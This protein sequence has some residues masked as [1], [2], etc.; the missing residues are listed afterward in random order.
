MK[1]K[2][3]HI[4]LL[5]LSLVIAA[6]ASGCAS[7]GSGPK[8]AYPT[9]RNTEVNVDWPM[10]RYNNAVTAGRV[11]L[12]M[13]QEVNQAYTA[14]KQAFDAALAAAN[15]NR[16]AHTPDNVQALANQL[17]TTLGGVPTF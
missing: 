2:T 9:L 14:Y 5:V 16:D 11:T 1:T 13:Q 7:G 10:T 17:L 6:F 12:G 3:C 8:G 15:N 4:V